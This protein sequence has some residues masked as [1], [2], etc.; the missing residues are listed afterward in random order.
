MDRDGRDGSKRHGQ[1]DRG[2][3]A[4]APVC[5]GPGPA[6]FTGAPMSEDW[7]DAFYPTL[8]DFKSEVLQHPKLRHFVVKVAPG[9]KVDFQ[10]QVHRLAPHPGYTVVDTM[11]ARAGDEYEVG[12]LSGPKPSL[13]HFQ[14]LATYAA[15]C[16]RVGL[17]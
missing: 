3:G 2:A 4:P 13:H 8:L 17:H 1:A 7:R 12:Y 14:Q 11:C 5:F 10:E 16:L 9:L 15:L 6:R